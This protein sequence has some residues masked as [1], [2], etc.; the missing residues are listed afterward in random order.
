MAPAAHVAA[1]AVIVAAF[2]A[3]GGAPAA[4]NVA[5]F[6][7]ADFLVCPCP[8]LEM[9]YAQC[10]QGFDWSKYIHEFNEV[11]Q[12]NMCTFRQAG[13]LVTRTPPVSPEKKSKP[14]PSREER[15]AAR[16][17]TLD[18]QFMAQIRARGSCRFFIAG[19]L[20]ASRRRSL[21]RGPALPPSGGHGRRLH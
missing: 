6:V 5:D 12:K 1:H 10:A 15:L 8:N 2:A 11:R 9:Q 16:Q 14:S 21:S 18:E 7:A 3:G 19:A 4:V 20:H 13:S 17:R